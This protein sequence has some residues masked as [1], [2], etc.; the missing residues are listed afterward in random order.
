VTAAKASASPRCLIAGR[1]RFPD[2]AEAAVE[3]TEQRWRQ[4]L[5][6]DPEQAIA[7]VGGDFALAL[8]LDDGSVFMAV[9]RFARQS[10]CYRLEGDGV[11]FAQ[12][13]DAF[14][15]APGI[16]PQALFDYLYFHVIPSPRTVYRGVARVPPG[17]CARMKNGRLTVAPYWTP[18]FAPLPRPSFDQLREEFRSVLRVA[19]RRQLDGS[20]PACFLSG[21]TDSSTVA[22]LIGEVA[23]KPAATYSIGFDAAGYDE[24]T[25]ARITARRYGTE[26]HEYYVTPADLVAS[27]PKVAAAYDQPFG[28]SSALPAYHCALQARGDGISR[29]LAGDGGD[30]LFGGNSRYATQRLFGWYEHVPMALRRGVLEPFFS[31]G[32]VGRTPL[33]KK[34][35]GY[36]RQAKTA[37]PERAQAFNLLRRLGFSEVLDRGFLAQVDA[38]SVMA[39]QVAVWNAVPDA[40]EID[41]HLAFDWRYTL[42]ENDLPKV[43]GTAS[44]AD[45]EVGFP[46]LDDDLLEFSMKLP[47][48]YKLRGMRL[49]WFFKEALRG[50]LPD[51]VITKKK[52]GFGLP[53]GLW[54]MRDAALRRLATESLQAVSSRGFVRPEFVRTLLEVRLAEAPQYYG[55]AIWILMMLEQWLRAHE[56]DFCVND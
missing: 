18:R 44:L 15:G 20:K 4:L 33:L 45:V 11:E 37:L 38:P 16:D 27:I 51:E 9:D 1:P 21:G 6:R 10:L 17:H 30:E 32:A 55:N 41:Q 46:L 22:G 13:A 19:V 35:T 28:N 56:P 53:F 43:V 48:D 34:G 50:F 26:H 49:R 24:M 25:F 54:M 14:G 8:T 31:L 47:G 42:A 5:R 2:I 7:R 52:H 36:I 3:T 12:R 40:S 39:Q 29:L 23:G